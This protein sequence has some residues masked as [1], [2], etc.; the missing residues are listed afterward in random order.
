MSKEI[1]PPSEV[2]PQKNFQ[3]AAFFSAPQNVVQLT[4][5]HQQITT[6]SPQKTTQELTHFT[7]T[8]CKNALPPHQKKSPK[9]HLRKC[10]THKTP[11][12][13]SPP[14]PAAEVSA[15]SVSPAPK[16]EASSN[17]F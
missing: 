6:T 4:T 5:A 15:S 16:P 11:S 17:P 8:P 10:S 12:S 14:R 7:K 3:K 1:P 2:F 13:R 9:L